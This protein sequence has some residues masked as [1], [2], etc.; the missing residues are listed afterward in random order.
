MAARVGAWVIC[1]KPAWPR[2]HR[3]SP[4]RSSH[5]QRERVMT[6]NEATQLIEE[7]AASIDLGTRAPREGLPRHETYDVIVIGGGQTGLSVG[8]HLARTGARFLILD[9]H[10]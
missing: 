7:G 6:F 10:R 2:P 4:P 5:R 3:V 8:Y 9:A 1:P